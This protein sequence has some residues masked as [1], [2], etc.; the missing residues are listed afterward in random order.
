MSSGTFEV[1]KRR[2][3]VGE[4]HMLR[5]LPDIRVAIVAD[6]VI[7]PKWASMLGG[8]MP[9]AWRFLCN[10]MQCP[11]CGLLVMLAR[12]FRLAARS[13]N[14]FCKLMLGLR[15]L[16]IGL[17]EVAAYQ[18]LLVFQTAFKLIKVFLGMRTNLGASTR[19]HDRLDLLPILTV[20]LESF[21]ELRVLL[22]TPPTVLPSLTVLVV[23]L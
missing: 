1:H 6:S 14:P 12:S 18:V 15:N 3:E 4:H 21:E 16:R 9:A 22:C 8:S 7:W 11:S 13:E 19:L 20:K 2:D 5:V 23:R 10:G 17:G